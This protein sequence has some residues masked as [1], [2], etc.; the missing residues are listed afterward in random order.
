[1]VSSIIL[2]MTDLRQVDSNI[3]PEHN[4]SQQ[5]QLCTP[6]ELE[7]PEQVSHDEPQ[8]VHAFLNYCEDD[9][10]EILNDQDANNQAPESNPY[11]SQ[12]QPIREMEL[13]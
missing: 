3:P 5:Q 4:N 2:T 6:G 7:V 12:E 13:H 10:D 8:V 1:M 9:Y 11:W